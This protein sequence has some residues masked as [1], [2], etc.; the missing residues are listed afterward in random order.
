MRFQKLYSWIPEITQ[1][2]SKLYMMRVIAM[3]KLLLCLIIV[4]SSTAV[5]FYY[6]QR[7]YVR[8]HILENFVLELQKCSTTMYYTSSALYKIFEHNFMDYHF[9]ENLSFEIQWNEMLKAY[10]D[11]LKKEDIELLSQFA[12]SI[13]TSDVDTEQKNIKMYI[14]ILSKNISDAENDINVKSKLYKTFGLSLGIII[15]I[16]LI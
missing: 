9:S 12:H 6:A 4:T 13:G 16:L 11:K 8:K 10:K 1:A 14:E 7:L 15:S 2:K 3:F 5:G